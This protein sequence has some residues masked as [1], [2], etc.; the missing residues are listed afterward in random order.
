MPADVR[1]WQLYR[2][3]WTRHAWS[4]NQLWRKRLPLPW[5]PTLTLTAQSAYPSRVLITVTGIDVG[6]VVTITRTPA[7]STTATTVRGAHAVTMTSNALV[8]VDAE[9]PYGVLLTYR[10]LIATGITG[11]DVE[12]NSATIT[13]TL[14]GSKV[15]LSD[16]VTGNAVEVVI[17]AWPEKAIER[18]SSVF[19]VGGRNIVVSGQGGGFASSLQ[20]FTET[21]TA[22]AAVVDLIKNATS[23]IVQL[24]QSGGYDD[25]DCYMF[26]QRITPTRWS[27]DG[28]D[29]RRI[30]ALDVVETGPWAPT[31]LAAT[32]T[33]EDVY[34]AYL[35]ESYADLAED[36]SSYLDLAI[37]DFS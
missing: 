14:A 33:Y 20:L 18:S 19:A 8:I 5:P 35:G 23:G 6:Q 25:V 12:Y 9:A 27:Q 37:G 7:G 13:L 3:E 32:F 26:V 17:L 21:D 16:A 22:R 24:R 1:H 2:R 30:I 31:L 4:A 10:L 29:Q 15:A 11:A 34:N 28:T 36:Y